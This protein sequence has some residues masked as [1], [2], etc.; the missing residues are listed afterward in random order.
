[1]LHTIVPECPSCKTVM[2][3]KDQF[4]ADDF[5]NIGVGYGQIFHFRFKCPKCKTTAYLEIV[6]SVHIYPKKV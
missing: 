2:V 4:V 3:Y 1:M 6:A 5:T